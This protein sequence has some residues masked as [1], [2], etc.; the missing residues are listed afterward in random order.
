MTPERKR[1]L[2]R[3][4]YDTG[5]EDL[6]IGFGGMPDTHGVVCD[7]QEVCDDLGINYDPRPL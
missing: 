6:G 4:W 1:A 5:Y 2:D 3:A 7:P